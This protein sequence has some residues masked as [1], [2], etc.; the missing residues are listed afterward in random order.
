VVRESAT[1]I[2]AVQIQQQLTAFGL[3]PAAVAKAWKSAQP[4]HTASGNIAKRGKK[5]EWIGQRDAPAHIDVPA[6]T[7][8]PADKDALTGDVLA[9]GTEH[10]LTTGLRLGELTEAAIGTIA[11]NLT[12][13]DRQRM[14]AA[15][16]AVP[17]PLGILDEPRT[18]PLEAATV[19]GV[20]AAAAA[21]IRKRSDPAPSRSTVMWLVGRAARATD[22]SLSAANPLNDLI[23][24]LVTGGTSADEWAS[25]AEHV[26][27]LPLSRIGG[28]MLLLTALGRTAP[29]LVTNAHWWTGIS[30]DQLAAAAAGPLG[31]VTSMP[32]VGDHVIRPLVT[33]AVAAATSRS[34]LGLLLALP[35]EFAAHVDGA[36]LASALRR[37]GR[38]D[39]TVSVW[40]R[41]LT[42]DE[43]V[44]A[45][46]SEVD[47][48][49]QGA[50]AAA[51]RADVA[52]RRLKELADRCADLEAEIRREHREA[53]QL[54][55]AQDRQVRIDVIR[56]VAGIA[57]EAEE[58][59]AGQADASVLIER[60]RVLATMQ[61]LEPI[62]R[63]AEPTLFDPDVHESIAGSP[64]TGT[65][66]AV[67][68][69]G[70]RWTAAG[71]TILIA[72]ALVSPQ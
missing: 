21:E 16:L 42:D 63:A 38:N 52:T 67:I 32:A 5:Y 26:S 35:V 60:I 22:L 14:F 43:R 56:A 3:D 51:D 37:V 57:A 58:L 53:V 17:K 62:G 64:D 49:R 45:L 44:D 40:L 46:H 29:N 27:A 55:A 28:R 19:D 59:A 18:L 7:T 23:A 1:P 30:L 6:P 41:A 71:E 54:R 48:A 70:Y 65:Q 66:V 72:R 68:R 13:S 39:P 33:A 9:G 47:L 34:Q 20:L 4:K 69:P 24:Y 10:P 2:D 31:R 61:D 36:S 8:Q 11:G 50:A 25:L 15:L 12:E